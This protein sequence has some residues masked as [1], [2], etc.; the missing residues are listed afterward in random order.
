MRGYTLLE[1]MV[2]LFIVGLCAGLIGMNISPGADQGA[3]GEAQRLARLFELAAD[4][5]S[6]SGTRIA[7]SS[8]G[9]SYQF[10]RWRDGAW[11]AGDDVLRARTLPTSVKVSALTVENAPA[12]ALRMTFSPY[13]PAL[14]YTVELSEGEKRYDVIVPPAGATQVVAVATQDATSVPN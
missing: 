12:T 8:D 4:E 5:A 1:I 10:W 13:G 11:Q 6:L 2:V 9:S 3:R 7:W 14:A